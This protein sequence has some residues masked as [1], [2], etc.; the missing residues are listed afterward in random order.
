MTNNWPTQF[1]WLEPN[2]YGMS[3]RLFAAL[4]LLIV[5][6]SGC[7]AGIG[8]MSAESGLATALSHADDL[9]EGDDT[10][11]LMGIASIEPLSH[12]YD[13][14]DDL[15]INTYADSVQGDGKLPGWAYGFCVGDDAVFIVLAAGLG[16]LADV[17]DG[18]ECEQDDIDEWVLDEWSV[19]S[20]EVADIL[21]D[22]PDWP[23]AREDSLTFF[24]LNQWPSNYAEE[25]GFE[26]GPYWE[27]ETETMDG[28][29]YAA[30]N[31][32]TGE[33]VFIES[34]TYPVEPDMNFV[35]VAEPVEE[36]CVE[37]SVQDSDSG[38]ITA[39]E[40]LE[41]TIE[42]PEDGSLEVKMNRYTLST[43]A[44]YVLE[45]PDGELKSGSVA[46]AHGLSIAGV[47]HGTY[48]LTVET[49]ALAQVDIQLIG[50]YCA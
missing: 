5:P 32:Q 50:T 4:S 48:T 37:E 30:V 27:V 23:E 15:E 12:Y 42:L 40:G 47:L 38:T 11:V 44:H 13:E 14:E 18:G 9:V 39:L 19:D 7:L 22:H 26:P 17:R 31:A 10:P 8:T 16:V 24:V 25:D 36:P 41:A 49:E 34:D 6:L 46:N 21:A 1:M 29:A 43:D 33:V 45:G 20:D 3:V 28:W 35:E 2:A